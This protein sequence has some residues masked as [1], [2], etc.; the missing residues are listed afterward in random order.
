MILYKGR[1]QCLVVRDGKI[2]MVKHDSGDYWHYCLP[3][4]GIEHGEIPEQA[5]IRELREECRVDGKIIKKTSE[6]VDPFD[7]EK[8]FYTYYMDIGNQTPALGIDPELIE[9]PILVEVRWLS[10]NEICEKDRAYLWSAG[11]VSLKEFAEEL[12]TWGKDISYPEKI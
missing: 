9:N 6:Y 11:L 8:F 4:G 12:D 1:A 5:A 3:G 7:D 2:L 10:L